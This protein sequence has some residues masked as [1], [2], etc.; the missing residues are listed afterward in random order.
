M[1]KEFTLK[2]DQ[3]GLYNITARVGE[4][5]RESGVKDGIAVV[6]CPHTTGGI[7]VN[8][9]ADDSV[10]GDLL[11]G[12]DRAFPDRPEFRHAEGNSAAHLKS[13]CVGVNQTIIIEKG[14]LLLGTWQGIYFCEF[15]GPR[16]RKFFVKVMGGLKHES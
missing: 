2:T 16:Q 8:E 10:R 9:N 11:L 12:L 3:E 15:D 7:T 14:K 4:T 1:L 5:V 13:S 6:W